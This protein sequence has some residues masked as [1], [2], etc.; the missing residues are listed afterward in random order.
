MPTEVIESENLTIACAIF[1]HIMLPCGSPHTKRPK[2][3]TDFICVSNHSKAVNPNHKEYFIAIFEQW[4]KER[5]KRPGKLIHWSVSISIPM[6]FASQNNPHIF[7]FLFSYVR[8]YRFFFSLSFVGV[9]MRVHLFF[10]KIGIESHLDAI[11]WSSVKH[12][13]QSQSILI[14]PKPATGLLMYVKCDEMKKKD[15]DPKSYFWSINI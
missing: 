15:P 11:C 9:K 12:N 4:T 7:I 10:T 3:K 6:R 8:V 2:K 5:E 14:A 13:H 1:S